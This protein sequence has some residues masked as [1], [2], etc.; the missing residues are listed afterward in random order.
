MK[1]LQMIAHPRLV[2]ILL[3][4]VVIIPLSGFSQVAKVPFA[5]SLITAIAFVVGLVSMVLPKPTSK[6]ARIFLALSAVLLVSAGAIKLWIATTSATGF[7]SCYQFQSPQDPDGF[8]DESCEATYEWTAPSGTSRLDPTIDFGSATQSD[9]PGTSLRDSNWNLSAINHSVYNYYDWDPRLPQRE[10]LPLD[11]YWS[12]TTQ[13]LQPLVVTYVGEGVLRI[14]EEDFPFVPNYRQQNQLIIEGRTSPDVFIYY[15]WSPP[16]DI[17]EGPYASIRVADLSGQPILVG[18]SAPT[19]LGVWFVL[20]A[21]L[22]SSITIGVCAVMVLVREARDPIGKTAGLQRLVVVSFAVWLASVLAG[23]VASW[24]WIPP[25]STSALL[26]MLTGLVVSRGQPLTRVAGAVA[27]GITSVTTVL[28][29]FRDTAMVPVLRGGDD[30]LTYESFAREILITG[31][32][33]AGEDVFWYAPGIRYSLFVLHLVFGDLSVWLW[34]FTLTITLAAVSYAI[35]RLT[36]RIDQNHINDFF[37]IKQWR[38]V[39]IILSVLSLGFLVG[40]DVVWRAGYVLFSEFPT[41]PALAVAF[42]LALTNRGDR[43]SLMVI[44]LLLGFCLTHRSNQLLGVLAIALVALVT[45]RKS[46]QAPPGVM[47]MARRSL[48]LFIPL[49]GLAGLIPLHN[50]VYGRR[51]VFT[52][53][54]DGLSYVTAVSPSS[55]LS[56]GAAWIALVR[57]IQALFMATTSDFPIPYDTSV[58]FGVYASLWSPTGLAFWFGFAGIVVVTVALFRRA[59]GTVRSEIFIFVVPL[60]FLLPHLFLNL[61]TYFPRHQV[62]GYLTLSLAVLAIATQSRQLEGVKDATNQFRVPS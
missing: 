6:R 51:L 25:V 7:N 8:R 48:W 30:F 40:S 4:T 9:L 24:H 22:T 28:V 46:H 38:F 49:I 55:L 1:F 18:T 13:D 12:G 37:S 58:D 39:A 52:H 14:G 21:F 59:Q 54:P 31:S 43:R 15:R 41:W 3:L 45:L 35:V 26:V 17:P 23:L 36:G 57:Q 60:G 32:L 5:D 19:R 2:G 61:S 33:R 42:T 56:D 47:A 20:L 10:R 53:D 62:A 44:G 29:T 16:A 11:A 50:W 34:V 27:I